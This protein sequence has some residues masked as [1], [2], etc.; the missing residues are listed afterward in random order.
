M[1]PERAKKIYDD[2]QKKKKVLSN[3]EY[4]KKQAD[5]LGMTVEEYRKKI[6][7]I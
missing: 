2:W 1:T 3:D 4:D 5:K 6:E 7:H